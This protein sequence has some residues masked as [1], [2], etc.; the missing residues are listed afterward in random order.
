VAVNS[1]E[2]VSRVLADFSKKRATTAETATNDDDGR[3]QQQQLRDEKPDF[4]A[5]VSE[6]APILAESGEE[7]SNG[8]GGTHHSLEVLEKRLVYITNTDVCHENEDLFKK[9]C[10]CVCVCVFFFFFFF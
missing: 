7:D 6:L 3:N 10:V 9:L 2:S 8:G 1:P 5:C 4:V